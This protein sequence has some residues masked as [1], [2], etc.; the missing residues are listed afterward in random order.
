MKRIIILFLSIAVFNSL[1]PQ[2][3][4]PKFSVT[5]ILRVSYE[6]YRVSV[7]PLNPS[8]FTQRRPSDQWR[9]SFQPI[10]SFG[11]FKLPFNIN[12]SPILNNLASPPFGLGNVPGFPKQTLIQW[13]TNPTN[14]IGVNP[15]YKWAE[16]QLGTQYLKYSDL[17][18]GDIGIFGYGFSLSLGKLRIKYFHGVSTQAYQSFVSVT[19][20]ITFIGAYKRTI[21][22][23]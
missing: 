20:P 22:I 3:K 16:L 10:F 8:F 21:N 6:G 7:D 14:N 19:P 17:S 18:S 12:A 1:W 2:V 11:E 9:F 15:T 5:G 23:N 4:P 13:L